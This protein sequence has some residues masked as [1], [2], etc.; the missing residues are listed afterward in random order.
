MMVT[1]RRLGERRFGVKQEIPGPRID[2]WNSTASSVSFFGSSRDRHRIMRW[3]KSLVELSARRERLE[4]ERG[5][6][7]TGLNAGPPVLH[8]RGTVQGILVMFSS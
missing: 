3:E 4:V 5:K 1:L 8:E 6:H 2:M 7:E